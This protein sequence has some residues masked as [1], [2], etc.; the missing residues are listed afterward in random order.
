MSETISDRVLRKLK[1]PD[2]ANIDNWKPDE[3]K[4]LSEIFLN[5][6]RTVRR[7]CDEI[8]ARLEQDIRP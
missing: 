6:A 3:L 2:A 5:L 8:E 4:F 1:H 7:M